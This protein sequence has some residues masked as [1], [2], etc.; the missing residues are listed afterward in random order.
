MVLRKLIGDAQTFLQRGEW[1]SRP[2]ICAPPNLIDD[3]HM[4]KHT[5]D[6]SLP[7]HAAGN[8]FLDAERMLFKFV[9]SEQLA[10]WKLFSDA[11]LGGK[12]TVSLEPSQEFPVSAYTPAASMATC[13]GTSL[14]YRML[15]TTN[16]AHICVCMTSVPVQNK[17]PQLHPHA[18]ATSEHAGHCRTQGSV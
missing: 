17:P 4:H 2:A 12:S 6:L 10:A 13:L 18:C 7:M 1:E 8:P 15:H 14:I 3:S 5:N 9:G 11:E 16:H